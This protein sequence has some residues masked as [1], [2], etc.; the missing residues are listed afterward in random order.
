MRLDPD[1]VLSALSGGDAPSLDSPSLQPT[2]PTMGELPDDANTRKPA[3]TRWAIPLTLVAVIAAAAIYEFSRGRRRRA[4]RAGS[5]DAGAS[6]RRA[7][8]RAETV[9]AGVSET[10]LPNPIGTPPVD[11]ARR[12][13]PAARRG[14]GVRTAPTLARAAT[15]APA[16]S[17]A[18]APLVL[19]FRDASWTE[20]KDAQRTACWSRR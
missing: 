14:A 20:V 3:W 7:R 11:R 19:T 10:P 8:V 15:A 6:D 1:A 12:R 13:E 5:A 18:E 4:A 2:A 17:A 9:R 16:P